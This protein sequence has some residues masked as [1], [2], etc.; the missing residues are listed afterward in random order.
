[1]DYAFAPPEI[2]SA[3]MYAGPGSGSLLA[4]AGSWDALSAE[5]ATTAEGYESVLSN[6][7][8]FQWRGVASEAMAAAAAHYMGW[9]QT[10][11][12]QTKQTAMQVRAAA[13][14]Y[15]HAHAT[16]VPPTAVAANRARLASL[17]ATN[18]VARTPPR[19]RPP[20]HSTATT[21][22]RT[23]QRCPATTP[24]RRPRRSSRGFLRPTNPPMR[25]G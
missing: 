17:I 16:T 3:R 1:M 23:L 20:R 6:L 7:T 8:S 5:L 15:E 11:T 18:V 13:S 21:G 4:A 10:A 19:S 22:P 2:N 12:E 25:P 9:L 14:A 24:L